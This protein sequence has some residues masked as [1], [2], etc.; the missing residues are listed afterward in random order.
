MFVQGAID[1]IKLGAM[2]VDDILGSIF[3]TQ[4]VLIVIQISLK[5]VLQVSTKWQILDIDQGNSL[6]PIRLQAPI[7][8]N[9]DPV[10]RLV[11]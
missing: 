7:L 3:L 11:S 1:V 2:F 9:D 6:V 4:Y 5:L 10:D 8:A